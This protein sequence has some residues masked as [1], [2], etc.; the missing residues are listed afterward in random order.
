MGTPASCISANAPT[1]PPRN[2]PFG[3]QFKLPLKKSKETSRLARNMKDVPPPGRPAQSECRTS[4]PVDHELVER[5][6]TQRY[7]LLCKPHT[8][9]APIAPTRNKQFRRPTQDSS[10]GVQKDQPSDKGHRGCALTWKFTRGGWEDTSNQSSL[11][12]LN[13]IRNVANL[14]ES[15]ETNPLARGVEMCLNLEIHPRAGGWEQATCCS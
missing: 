9:H 5:Q 15:R 8:N 2:Q 7:T 10:V 13:Q 1:P 14:E 11:R 3:E 4:S 12:S 6:I